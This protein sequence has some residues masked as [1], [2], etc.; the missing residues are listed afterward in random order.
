LRERSARSEPID[1][2]IVDLMMPELDGMDLAKMIDALPDLAGVPKLLLSSAGRL[3][4]PRRLADVHII[5]ALHKPVKQSDLLNAI[6]E[7]VRRKPALT[8]AQPDAGAPAPSGPQL[9]VLLAED[10]AINQRV[11]ID[12]LERRGHDVTVANNGREAVAHYNDGDFDVVL[13][14][15]QMPEL[16]GY[17]ATEQIRA[18]EQQRGGHVPI[19]AMT[20]NAMKGDRERCL[21][22]GMDDYIAK[23]IRAQPFYQVIESITMKQAKRDAAPAI[24]PAPIED[25]LPESDVRDAVVAAAQ[26]RGTVDTV[27]QQAPAAATSPNASP[28]NRAAALEITGSA[29]AFADVAELFLEQATRLLQ[30][31]RDAVETADAGELRLAAHTLKGSASI[32][33][34][35]A[36][37]EAARE[38][39]MIGADSDLTDAAASVDRLAREMDRLAPALQAE[40]DAAGTSGA[41]P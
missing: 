39:E 6:T 30:T 23:P 14:D 26:P 20:A 7:A 9:R 32:F 25:T 3:I 37:F 28:F 34:A 17:G 24:Q 18:L 1:L 31:M 38:V 10:N 22:A 27:A 29:S 35:D 21:A 5:R 36:T 33:A 8:N 41:H 40:V 16:D 12:L 2:V 19:I 11:A 13:M 15:V 4:D